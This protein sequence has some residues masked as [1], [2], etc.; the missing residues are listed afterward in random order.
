MIRL[1]WCFRRR[2][3]FLGVGWFVLCWCDFGFVV[4]VG[5][6]FCLCF[7]DFGCCCWWCC[8][9]LGCWFYGCLGVWVWSF[10]VWGFWWFWFWWGFG[11]WCCWIGVGCCGVVWL[12]GWGLVGFGCYLFRCVCWFWCVWCLWGLG[13]MWLVVV[14]FGC[15]WWF[16]WCWGG[17]IWFCL[18][19]K[20]ESLVGVGL[21][22]D[23][24]CVG[25]EWISIGVCD[26]V[27]CVVF[28]LCGVLLW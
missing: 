24:W 18:W 19:W 9:W 4:V 10:G 23:Y 21:R 26:G 7:V 5:L 2:G 1:V 6:L 14:C 27:V 20:V 8:V 15:V 13:V 17:G 25:V 16:W 3:V 12:F 11:G 28:F 22:Y